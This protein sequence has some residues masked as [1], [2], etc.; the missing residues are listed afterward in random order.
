MAKS[1]VVF[2]YLSTI[3]PNFRDG[4]LKGNIKELDENES[5]FHNNKQEYYGKRLEKSNE[6]GVKYTPEQKE[7]DYW[8]NLSLTEFWSDYDIVYGRADQD[9]TKLISLQNGIGLIRKRIQSPAILR[10][11][12]NYSNDEDLA[13]GLLILFKPFR[14]EM[15]D[16]HC[17]DVHCKEVH[18]KEVGACPL[19]NFKG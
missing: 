1:S 2:K 13:R 8:K 9:N 10:Y 12:L 15:D 17:K 18:C 16:I 6:T 3:H 19:A 5:I 11:Y 4:L 7:K 14:N